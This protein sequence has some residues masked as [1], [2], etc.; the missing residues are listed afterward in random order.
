EQPLGLQTIQGLA[1]R[2]GLVTALGELATQL[3]SGVLATGQQADG[4]GATIAF[5]P[6]FRRQ[7]WASAGASA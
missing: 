7:A 5:G 4:R 1:N 6:G 2:L 3:P